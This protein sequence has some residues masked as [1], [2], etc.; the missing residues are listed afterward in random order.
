MAH[1][2]PSRAQPSAK[3]SDSGVGQ[4]NSD[5]LAPATYVEDRPDIDGVLDEP[6]W[7]LIEPISDFRQR[8]PN[9]GAE[10]TERTEVRIAYDERAIY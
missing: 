5:L 8:V 4:R 1:P 3:T 7:Q 9:E 10:P 2:D 6:F